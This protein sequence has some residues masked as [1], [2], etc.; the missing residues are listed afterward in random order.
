MKDLIKELKT[1]LCKR[2]GAARS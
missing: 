1:F 2:L